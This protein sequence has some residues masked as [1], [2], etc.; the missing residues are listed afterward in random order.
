MLC[1]RGL[2]W[3][4]DTRLRPC[5][6]VL[7]KHFY[8]NI[9]LRVRLRLADLCVEKA[10]YPLRVVKQHPAHSYSLLTKAQ[11]QKTSLNRHVICKS[12]AHRYAYAHISP[13]T[14]THTHTYTATTR[15]KFLITGPAMEKI[16]LLAHEKKAHLCIVESNR[17]CSERIPPDGSPA[18]FHAGSSCRRR[19]ISAGRGTGLTFPKEKT[20]T[21]SLDDS[22]LENQLALAS[23]TLLILL[24]SSI[25]SLPSSLP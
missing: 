11:I 7:S 6:S 16:A 15:G 14:H 22:F 20:R 17:S 23:G 10:Y 21:G 9:L 2:G 13:G 1:L 19:I 3:A 25:L 18:S 12:H 4:F 5:E 8:S 24:S